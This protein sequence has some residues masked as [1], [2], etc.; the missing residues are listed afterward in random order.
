[1]ADGTLRG[2]ASRCRFFHYL[3]V[4]KV[5]STTVVPMTP[6]EQS[7]RSLRLVSAA[8]LGRG[9][10]DDRR[11]IVSNRM[12]AAVRPDAPFRLWVDQ[13]LRPRLLPDDVSSG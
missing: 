3:S 10:T 6:P 13:P 11:S 8:N 5:H 7:P 9:G 2:D 12:G 1:M 4:K